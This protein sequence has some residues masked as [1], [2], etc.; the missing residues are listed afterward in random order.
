MIY[1]SKR[2]GLRP[3]PFPA[4]AWETQ[5]TSETPDCFFPPLLTASRVPLCE[6]RIVYCADRIQRFSREKRHG[7]AAGSA[8]LRSGGEGTEGG[9]GSD[10]V[11]TLVCRQE[12]RGNLWP[13]PP[14]EVQSI[15]SG[16]GSGESRAGPFPGRNSDQIRQML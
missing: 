7:R 6:N 15:K 12:A 10:V 9:G 1:L 5:S 3:R 16:P 4:A 11:Q 2:L 13:G 14:P 8:A